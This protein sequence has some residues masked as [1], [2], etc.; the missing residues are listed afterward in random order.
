MNGA[1]VAKAEC[2]ICGEP[3][4]D[5]ES[6]KRGIGPVCAAKFQR[7]LAAAGSSL[8]E[9]GA[10]PLVDDATVARWLRKIAGAV[11]SGRQSEVELFLAAARRAAK[12][13]RVEAAEERAA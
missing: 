4:T 8:D 10:L 1:Q 5:P 11:N 7:F 12:V 13:A 9:I 2:H 3:L 6:V